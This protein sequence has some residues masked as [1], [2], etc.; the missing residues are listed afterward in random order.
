MTRVTAASAALGYEV[1]HSGRRDLA[2]SIQTQRSS[3]V[4]MK[5][6]VVAAIAAL[7]LG[8][9]AAPSADAKVAGSMAKP[10]TTSTNVAHPRLPAPMW[11]G[12]RPGRWH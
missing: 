5:S 4:S 1:F 12:R 3:T 9:G 6:T 10:G 7:M 2:A 8:F 11:G